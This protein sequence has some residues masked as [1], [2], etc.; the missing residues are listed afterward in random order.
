MKDER[1]KKSTSTNLGIS[2][3]TLRA[4]KSQSGNREDLCLVCACETFLNFE[5]AN[6]ARR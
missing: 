6:R 2:R 3:L 1:V 4:F 5:R